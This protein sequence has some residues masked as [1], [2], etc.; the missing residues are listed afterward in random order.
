MHMSGAIEERMTL[1]VTVTSIMHYK[2]I[3]SRL[4][5]WTSRV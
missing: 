3:Q 2:N 5:T 1:T 4:S